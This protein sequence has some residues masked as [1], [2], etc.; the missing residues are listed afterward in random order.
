[1]INNHFLIGSPNY[2]T[3][4]FVQFNGIYIEGTNNIINSLKH[5]GKK[6]KRNTNEIEIIGIIEEI[7]IPILMYDRSVNIN[8]NNNGLEFLISDKG[9]REQMISYLPQF[10]EEKRLKI[11]QDNYH[12]IL[13]I[14]K[15]F[16]L[17]FFKLNNGDAINENEEKEIFNFM[18]NYVLNFND[19]N[20]FDFGDWQRLNKFIEN[21]INEILNEYFTSDGKESMN[22]K[23][24]QYLNKINFDQKNIN[25]LIELFDKKLTIIANKLLINKEYIFGEEL[26]QT[27][28]YLFSVFIQFFEGHLNNKKLKKYFMKESEKLKNNSFNNYIGKGK[29]KINE[30]IEIKKEINNNKLLNDEYIDWRIEIIYQFIEK[31]K[32]LLGFNFNEE[33]KM[34]QNKRILNYE[35]ENKNSEKYDGPFHVETNELIDIDKLIEYNKYKHAISSIFGI[36]RLEKSKSD[37]FLGK[38][39]ET[40]KGKSKPEI[41]DFDELIQKILKKLF[42]YLNKNISKQ[43]DRKGYGT[44]CLN[45]L[46]AY[47]CN[48]G[49]NYNEQDAEKC[50]NKYL[51][52]ALYRKYQHYDETILS[53]NFKETV[54]E[55]YGLSNNI[56]EFNNKEENIDNISNKHSENIRE[57][58]S[59][60][61]N[62]YN[63]E[64]IEKNIE[65]A[66]KK[67]WIIEKE[68]REYKILEN[69]KN[70]IKE[71]KNEDLII[72]EEF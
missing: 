30:I 26:T 31:I 22:Y 44:I 17:N 34:L 15:N 12:Y 46:A 35:K 32:K 3:I 1:R 37:N 13:I 19:K 62:E 29:E 63:E 71:N 72:L 68:Q 2:G 28:I 27:D 4:P 42:N 8:G 10:L 6:I 38:I 21:F 16:W 11:V 51:N 67:S 53:T 43:F 5:L 58:A 36:K 66:I 50:K 56:K 14:G 24:K 65:E 57:I 61:I 69:D 7:I 59:K 47:L 18:Q 64:K 23:I 70:E 60:I 25:N 33:W 52:N 55:V 48:L 54:K 39:K 45:I 9:I 41:E 40:I 20:S 49:R